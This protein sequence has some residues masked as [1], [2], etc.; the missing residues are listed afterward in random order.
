MHKPGCKTMGE[1]YCWVICQGK[2]TAEFWD[3]EDYQMIWCSYPAGHEPIND[4]DVIADHG[5]DDKGVYFANPPHMEER[6]KFGVGYSV[7]LNGNLQHLISPIVGVMRMS[8]ADGE[9]L[10]G[11]LLAHTTERLAFALQ[12]IRED[13]DGRGQE[14]D[15]S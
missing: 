2:C 7:N 4:F 1:R 9:P 13:E 8:V 6:Q 3:D 10:S 5:N 15:N 14:P 11:E 12:L